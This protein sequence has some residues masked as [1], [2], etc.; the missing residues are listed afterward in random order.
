MNKGGDGLIDY[1][2][3]FL[4]MDA[5]PGFPRPQL[6]SGPPAALIHAETPPVWYFLALY[7]AVGTDYDWTDLH[8]RS[9]ERVTSFLHDP[10]VSLYTL[11]RS[12]WPH[13]FFL[14][15]AR[16]E[17]RCNL[18]Y[19]GLVP[20]AIGTGLGRFLLETAVHL[21]WDHPGVE[22]ISVN[23]CSLDHPRALP[24]YQRAGFEPVRRETRQ[25]PRR[26]QSTGPSA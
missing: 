5:R 20:E 4:Q 21:A 12:G 9:R 17:H 6:P 2:V 23:T 15:D 14:L 10:N 22:Q 25:R 3:T 16:A 13:G 24:L 26:R 1:V 8:A 18:A 7:D 11:L 19:F